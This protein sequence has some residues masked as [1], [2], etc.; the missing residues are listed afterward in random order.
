[1]RRLFL[2]HLQAAFDTGP[3]RF[4]ASLEHLRDPQAFLRYLADCTDRRSAEDDSPVDF[5]I[6]ITEAALAEF[7]EILAY[8]WANFSATA[9]RFGNALLNHI[10]LLSGLCLFD[11]FTNRS[12]WLSTD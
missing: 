5:Q 3:L 2:D 10:D 1:L 11:S 7:E 8:S 12:M 9:E 6:R 4:F